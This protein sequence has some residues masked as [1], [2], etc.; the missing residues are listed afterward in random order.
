KEIQSCCSEFRAL[1][2]LSDGKRYPIRLDRS[3]V[4]RASHRLVAPYKGEISLIRIAR[5]LV[6]LA[7]AS[8]LGFP[9]GAHGQQTLP[10][11]PAIDPVTSQLTALTRLP[12]EEWRYHAGDLPH[13]EAVALDDSAWEVV[14]KDSV[15][16]QGAVWYRR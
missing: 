8:I 7:F 11:N 4:N 13:G 3:S 9:V 12:A 10:P 2:H 16:P 5:A 15:A 1:L 6:V 14:K